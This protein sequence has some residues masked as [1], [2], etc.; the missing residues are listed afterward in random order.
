MGAR[1]HGTVSL[2]QEDRCFVLPRT[3]ER[4]AVSWKERDGGKLE[5]SHRLVSVDS[6]EVSRGDDLLRMGRS[7]MRNKGGQGI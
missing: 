2:E 1:A 7:G 3:G 4:M 6:W 5:N